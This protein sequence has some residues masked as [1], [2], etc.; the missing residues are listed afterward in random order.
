M[1]D[2]CICP[3]CNCQTLPEPVGDPTKCR[4]ECTECGHTDDD[5]A[6]EPV[7]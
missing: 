6:F 1:D 3:A 5:S 2:Y 4:S 7:E